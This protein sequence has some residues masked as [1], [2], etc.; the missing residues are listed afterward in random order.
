LVGEL[1]GHNIV[2]SEPKPC[3]PVLKRAPHG[4]LSAMLPYIL[5]A[6]P[7]LRAAPRGNGWLHEVKFDGWRVQVHKY[8]RV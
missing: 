8:G 2:I 7:V 6:I 4:T 5:P 1:N 3:G